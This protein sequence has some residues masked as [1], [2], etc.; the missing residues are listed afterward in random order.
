[1]IKTLETAFVEMDADVLAR[2]TE[3]ALGRMVAIKALREELAPKRREMGEWA[4]YARMFAV[5][6][7]KSWY[8]VLNGNNEVGV[9]AFV[10]KN[11]AAIA[12]KRN[13]TIVTKLT[14]IGVT[15][16]GDLKFT[17]TRDGFDGTF[18]FN[19]AWIK[20]QTIIAGGYNVQ[21]LHYR[22]LVHAE[23]KRI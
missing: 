23:G 6:G 22:T 8:N 3:W 20:I 21:C 19:G 12:A 16:L 1:M 2:Q 11:C 13:A 18:E 5:A 9:K 10:I 17:R 4:Y 14:K 15:E 7:G